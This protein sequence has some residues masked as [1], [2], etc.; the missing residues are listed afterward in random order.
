MEAIRAT[1]YMEAGLWREFRA[2]CALR[3]TNASEVLRA[4]TAQQLATWR[5]EEI[6]KKPT[7]DK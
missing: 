4:L 3:S 5:K 7:T 6:T 2:A 1:I